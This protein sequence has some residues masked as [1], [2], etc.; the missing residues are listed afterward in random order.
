MLRFFWGPTYVGSSR[1]P[2]TTA[3]RLTI[4][5]RLPGAELLGIDVAYRR[6]FSPDVWMA[7]T[8]GGVDD[9]GDP[10]TQFLSAIG[11]VLLALRC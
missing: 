11:V 5:G 6:A 2:A 1:R 7:G 4:R 3:R 9:L 10:E 8:Q